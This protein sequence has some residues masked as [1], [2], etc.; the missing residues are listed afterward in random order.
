[1]LQSKKGIVKDT[2]DRAL[3]VE[4][5][6]NL[7]MLVPAARLRDC[8]EGGKGWLGF[9]PDGH[10]KY[11]SF[12]CEQRICP[13]CSHARSLQL[14][15]KLTPALVKLKRNTPAIYGLKHITLGT[16]VNIIEYMQVRDGR[17]E[18]DRSRLDM[19]REKVMF[20]R[21]CVASLFRYYSGVGYDDK[22]N[23]VP[24]GLSE[25]GFEVLPLML[26]FAIGIE[27]G[28]KAGSLHFHILCLS[29]YIPH[30]TISQDWKRHNRSHGSYCWV[31]AV[32]DE[33]SDIAKSVGY[34]TKYVTK[35]LG[36]K[37]RDG[38]TQLTENT[39]RMA[40]WC[41]LWGVESVIAAM[42]YVFKGVRRLQTYGA[43]FALEF[44]D[45]PE[46]CCSVCGQAFHWVRELEFIRDPNRSFLES[47]KT[48]KTNNFC[49]VDE[50]PPDC[51]SQLLLF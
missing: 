27:F 28:M 42:A 35:P 37:D 31:E 45:E 51:V 3:V 39:A 22:G 47:L 2:F 23:I 6:S 5:L 30:L 48:L 17:R 21:G 16:D 19:L 1:M 14:G 12:A 18:L 40:M 38:D 7:G 50:P 33:D 20:L 36:G 29:K 9:C 4:W 25:S 24:C 44:D 32:G 11:V 41:D 8:G 49:I 26:G 10:E 46:G 43:F 34:V 13:K 15:E